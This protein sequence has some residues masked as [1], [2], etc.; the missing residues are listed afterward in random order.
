MFDVGIFLSVVGSSIRVC[1]CGDACGASK[2]SE[3]HALGILEHVSGVFHPTLIKNQQEINHIMTIPIQ[4][5]ER[6]GGSAEKRRWCEEMVL[7]KGQGG[8]QRLGA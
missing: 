8:D 2:P 1:V 5:V 4:N 6:Q 7:P 3:K